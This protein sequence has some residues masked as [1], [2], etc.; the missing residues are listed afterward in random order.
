MVVAMIA[1]VF[2]DVASDIAPMKD[3]A[4]HVGDPAFAGGGLRRLQWPMELLIGFLHNPKYDLLPVL[5]CVQDT[6]EPLRAKLMWGFDLPYMITGFLNQ[7]PRSAIKFKEAKTKG[8]ISDFYNE[9]WE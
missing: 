1:G 5:R 7:H 2:H 9:I 4:F 3:H 6:I 8:E